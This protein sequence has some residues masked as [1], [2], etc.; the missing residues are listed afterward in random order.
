MA[1]KKTPCP[2]QGPGKQNPETIGGYDMIRQTNDDLD[3]DYWITSGLSAVYDAGYEEGRGGILHFHD[4]L[5]ISKGALGDCTSKV[6]LD[7]AAEPFV[8]SYYPP[9]SLDV[10][11]VL[12]VTASMMSGG[13]RKMALAK[14]A[15]IQ[16]IQ[17]LWRQNQETRITIVP[18]ARDAYIPLA[19]GG[20]SYD[21]LGTLFT[22]RR[23][24]VGGN[25]IGQ[26]LGYRN[27]SYVSASEIPAYMSQS[28]PIAASAERSLYNYYNYYKIQYS[29]IYHADG[30][31]RTDTILENYLQ[32]VYST[33]PAAYTGNFITSVASGT[34]LTPSQ[35]PY[36]MNDTGYEANTILDNMI[37]AIPYGEDTNTEAGLNEAYRLLKTPGFTQSDDILRRAVILITD[38]Q[39]NRSVNPEYADVYAGPSNTDSDFLPEMP[40]GLWK[41]YLYLRQTLPRLIQE[42]ASRSAT[43]EELILALKRAYESAA[44]IKDPSDG[45]ASLF[46]LGIEIDA[47]TPGPYTREDVLNIMRTIASTGSY[48][49]EAAESGSE[50]PIIE[51]LERLVRDLLV[52][53]GSLR[54]SLKDTINTALFEYVPGS[55][56]ISGEQDGI[57][58]KTADDPDITD[59]SAPGYT[60]YKKPPL[61]PIVDDGNIQDGVITVDLGN[62]P[63]FPLSPDSK[64]R[65][66]LSYEITAKG[67][68][69][70]SHLHTNNDRETFVTFLEPSHLTADTAVLT[71]DNPA[72]TLHFPTPVVS[73]HPDVT[74]EKFVGTEADQIIYKSLDAAACKKVYYRIAVRN[75]SDLPAV[76]PLLYDVF[77]A[78]SADQAE[79]STER[80]I[81]AEDFTVPPHDSMEFTF[82]YKTKCGDG[83]I[84]NYAVLVTSL[85]NLYDDTSIEVHDD[86]GSYTVQYLDRCTGNR[87]CPDRQVTDVN[88]CDKIKA[89]KLAVCIPCWRYV[90]ACPCEID[91][92]RGE[93]IIKLYYVPL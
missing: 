90:S 79:H 42:L 65:L 88:A 66:Q 49:R 14:R 48:L 85:C 21:Y 46:V 22:W 3:P 34:P 19:G 54:L 93:N 82:E 16:T 40:G 74:V 64:T 70:G 73:C 7:V 67:A 57:L 33:D 63:F 45:N 25:M 50:R 12:D 51:E 36:S 31:A 9:H 1:I 29:D 68:A 30:S 87:I 24:T 20:F 52:L 6:T 78:K 10:I 5:S 83:T 15:L 58:L 80:R 89:R 56:K 37:W 91:L 18:F 17:L 86:T 76:F 27:G 23:S 41:Y 53:A 39:A 26:I 77:G 8:Y 44:K 61:L 47:Q 59:P 35:L 32:Q 84:S 55:L 75:H 28:A 38:G 2:Y 13:S 92:C 11:F 4:R 72:R 60:V 69:S 43:S 71:Y 81:L 62:V